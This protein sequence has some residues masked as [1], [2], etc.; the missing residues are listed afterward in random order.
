MNFAIEINRLHGLAIE[1]AGNAIDYAKQA[2]ALLLEVKRS[3]P[4]G[5]FLPWLSENVTVSER[6]AQRY[7]R[8]A[9]GKPATV[10]AIK[11][12]TVSGLPDWLPPSGHVGIRGFPEGDMLL[13]QE[14][15]KCAG[16]Y[17]FAFLFGSELT[18]CARGIRADYVRDAV[19]GILPGSFAAGLDRG[20]DYLERDSYA[21]TAM[22][23]ERR[24][25][26]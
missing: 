18:Q 4:H 5:A 20:W 1:H 11:S 16:Y 9:L 14:L 3:M 19:I 26:Q 21:I 6:Q 10:R 23:S 12:D 25:K 7:M 8:V 22:F 24:M 2:G 13:V 15:P 17:G